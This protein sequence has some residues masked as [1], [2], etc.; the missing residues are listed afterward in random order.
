MSR[1]HT[2]T[3]ADAVEYARQFGQI[4][5]PLAL[6]TADEIGDGNLNLVFKIR[7][8]AGISR[9]IVKQALPYV[10][11]VG[12]SWPLTLDRARIEAETLLTHGQ[13]CPQHTVNVL[14]HDAELAVMVQEDLSDHEIWRSELVK[15]KYYPQAA[16]QLAEYLAQT[17]F[18]T[19]D[20]Y[21]SAQAKKA[22]VSRYTNPE[23][24]QITEDLFFTDPYIDHE[25]NNFDP[26]LL[27]EVLALRQDDAL[28]LAVAS[29]KHRFLSKA[30]ALLHG[31]IHSGSIFVADGCL[32]AIDAEFGFYGPIG[33]DV[34]TA[35]GN[36]LLN[37]C[38]LPGLAGP[39]D[40]AA[41]REQRLKDIHILWETFS[42]SFLALCKEKIQDS[43]LAT[44][45]YARLFL[46]QVWQDAVGYCGSELIRRTIGLAHVAD[47]DSIAD[48]EM[49]RA[50]QRH[51]L[52]LGRTLILAAPRIDSIDDLIARIR[53]NG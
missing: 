48:D 39:R 42:H 16:G 12:E 26:A 20:F 10:R 22:A 2:F 8:A 29:L 25:R 34:G 31:D 44:A 6:V 36:L 5:D 45:G 14:H 4:A 52:S 21:Q 17:L 9:V 18:H 30:E 24:C 49:R 37:Y 28:K 40:A 35:L 3:A 11:C 38:G 7:D 13:F 41:G 46:Q 51:A 43:A 1:Y 27:S 33:F 50:C 23:L 32:K 15:G 53:Q 19:S 47:L